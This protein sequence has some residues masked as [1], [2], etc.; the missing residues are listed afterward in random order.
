MNNRT[1]VPQSWRQRCLALAIGLGAT[2]VATTGIQAEPPSA[3]LQAGPQP[4]VHRV[5]GVA[6]ERVQMVANS[7]RVLSLE[8]RIPKVEVS[9]PEILRVTPVSANEVQIYAL[10]SGVT[11]VNLWTEANQVY[12]LDV[13]VFGDA[14]ELTMYL[15]DLFPKS[16]LRVIPMASSAVIA[17]H[18]DDPSQV[19][20]VMRIAENFYPEPINAINVGNVQQV[21]LKVKVY[22]VSRTKLRN[23]GFDFAA[24]T[25]GGSV[26]AS[27]VSGIL[28][29]TGNI[30]ALTTTGN[31]TAIASVLTNGNQFAALLE[32]LRQDDLAK[33]LAEPNLIAISGRP[34][35]F[36][37]GGEFPILV[38][39][40]LGTVSIMY[41]PYGTQVDF[42]PIV[43][44]NGRVRLE[45]RPR[46][47]EIDA[48]R[49]VTI[50]GTTVPALRVRE[51]DTAVEMQAGQTLAIGG[52]VQSR[53]EAQSRGFPGLKE[54]PL[55]GG[56]FRRQH[57]QVNEI[58]LL[59][60]V[61]PEL[62][63]A[64]NPHEV[65]PCLPGDETTSPSDYELYVRGYLEV[66]KRCPPGEGS[67][68]GGPAVQPYFPEEN[69]QPAPA[70][71]EPPAPPATGDESARRATSNRLSS[72]V[73]SVPAP[74]L[75]PS[76]ERAL[77][78]QVAA[79]PNNPTNRQT[80]LYTPPA[81]SNSSPGM[82]GRVGYDDVK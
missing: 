3:N 57:E 68:P 34:A 14:R 2:L 54:I 79:R 73:P 16:S 82:F 46:V 78:P 22:E 80:P 32:A 27:A 1:A 37:A 47:S 5:R 18:V 25:S 65:P 51:I 48:A 55:V 75:N 6:N 52:L 64:M 12:T 33:V 76:Q 20:T 30:G 72:S 4:V 70:K 74:R 26:Y 50:N 49:S 71:S 9:N 62:V 40:S 10:R 69:A 7:S 8:A 56:L 31:Q 59:I 13:S 77:V 67:L 23:L 63:D 66:P 42:V 60:V 15:R 11:Q 21:L 28:K 61:T 17:G 24:V 58:E 39:Q 43:L 38:P 35:Y 36:N 19:A 44:G 41:R 45:V 29:S 53:V 81:A